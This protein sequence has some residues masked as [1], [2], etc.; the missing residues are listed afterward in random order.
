MLDRVSPLESDLMERSVRL[1]AAERTV[2][3]TVVGHDIAKRSFD[4]A[5]AVLVL[6]FTAPLLLI[7]II[8]IL[9]VSPGSPFFLQRRIGRSG[10]EFT[11]IKLRTMRQLSTDTIAFANIEDIARSGPVF[12]ARLDPRVFRFG[13]ILRKTSVD[14]L[15]NLVN[16]LRGEMSIVGPRPMQPVEIAHCAAAFGEGVSAARLSVRPG[17]TCLWQVSGRSNIAFHERIRMDVAYATGWNF[18]DDL[19]IIAATVPA[20][21]TRRGAY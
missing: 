19:K 9:S 5:I 14:E 4:I 2:T 20:V 7:A 3:T 11:L 6:L 16:V 21:L 1:R 12:K 18:V 10:K 15:P 17:I 8:G 13:S